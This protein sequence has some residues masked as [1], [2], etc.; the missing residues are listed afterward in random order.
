MLVGALRAFVNT[1][2]LRIAVTEFGDGVGCG[3]GSAATLPPVVQNELVTITP[4]LLQA[5]ACNQQVGAR[6][7][8]CGTLSTDL[9][10]GAAGGHAANAH[11]AWCGCRCGRL[12]GKTR[13]YLHGT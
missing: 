7:L 2:C 4:V 1:H 12:L 8:V 10:Q 5:A 11:T 3:A 6:A 9:G 13:F